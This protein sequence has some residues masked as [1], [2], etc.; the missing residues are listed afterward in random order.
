MKRK[1][2]KHIATSLLIFIAFFLSS[3]PV[4]ASLLENLLSPFQFLF[5][6]IFPSSPEIL[7]AKIEPIKVEPSDYMIITATVKDKYGIESVKADM[8]GIELISLTLISGNEKEGNYQAN[9]FVH[10]VEVGKTYNATIIARNVKGKESFLVLQFH[11]DPVFCCRINI[12]N[13]RFFPI[14]PG[15]V[16]IILDTASLI[17]QGKMRSDC[18]DIRF[19]DSKAF[20]AAFWTRNFSYNLVG[21]CNSASTIFNVEVPS[22]VTSFYAY[23]G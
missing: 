13:L 19:T 21:G 10:D 23:Y 20:D 16:G 6:T 14:A 18:G 4:K 5:E 3:C 12:S 8:A 7:E 22:G 2:K 15:I 11:D 9:W 17:S 1:M